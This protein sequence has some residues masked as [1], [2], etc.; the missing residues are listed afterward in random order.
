VRKYKN[1][2]N[3]IFTYNDYTL[4][5]LR[6]E[7]KYDILKIRNEQ[8]YH[9]RQTEPLTA[10]KQEEYFKTVVNGLFEQEQPGQLLF[11]Y[12]KGNEFIGYGGLVHINWKDK[13]AEISFVIK[14]ELEQGYFAHHW[15]NFLTLLEKIAFGELQLHKIFTY[16]FDLRPH[17]YDVLLKN[18]YTEES[19]LKEHCLFGEKYI[20]VVIHS[21]WNTE[22]QP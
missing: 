3:N 6:D 7:D 17:L 8:I 15:S 19:R 13:N 18:S 2:N 9:L 14:T 1:L 11:S 20:D 22:K 10:T 12:L 5:P 21:K 4:C 16:A